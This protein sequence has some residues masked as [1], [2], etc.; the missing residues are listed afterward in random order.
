MQWRKRK[1]NI[2]RHSINV[3]VSAQVFSQ[4][5]SAAA[6]KSAVA[7]AAVLRFSTNS[8]PKWN[9][10][11]MHPVE[12]YRIRPTV[13]WKSANTDKRCRVSINKLNRF[14]FRFES[15]ALK[16]ASQK[17]SGRV[18]LEWDTCFILYSA[19]QAGTFYT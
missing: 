5:F 18:R 8:N 4:I 11:C 7:A 3:H 19:K 13:V 16:S 1:M 17:C 9:K 15:F 2:L 6:Q 10:Y 14:T 12:M